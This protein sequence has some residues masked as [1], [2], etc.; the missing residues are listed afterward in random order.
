[1][2]EIRKAIILPNRRLTNDQFQKPEIIEAAAF[3]E[4]FA[5]CQQ[6]NTLPMSGGLLDQDSYFVFL[7]KFAL[8]CQRERQE[9]D[10]RRR[11][12]AT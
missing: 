10:E 1:M 4:I 6:M 5:L 2:H 3:I 8:T 9:L 12:N 7:L 11:K